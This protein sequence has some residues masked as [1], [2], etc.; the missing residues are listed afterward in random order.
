MNRNDRICGFECNST[1]EYKSLYAT[2]I[3]DIAIMY[4]TYVYF[5]VAIVSDS[6]ATYNNE[7]RH[8]PAKSTSELQASSST[9]TRFIRSRY[10]LFFCFVL[11]SVDL[12]WVMWWHFIS[13]TS[14]YSKYDVRWVETISVHY[15]SLELSTSP[16][17]HPKKTIWCFFQRWQT[18]ENSLDF[19]FLFLSCGFLYIGKNSP[20]IR[21]WP[22]QETGS[23]RRACS[24]PLGCGVESR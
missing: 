4:N 7:T 13:V 2:N 8:D 6:T 24:V 9:S 19:R 17:P 3:D 20:T 1:N 23:S 12:P 10:L 11:F 22:P 21:F 14:L 5:F 16:A 15:L 18:N